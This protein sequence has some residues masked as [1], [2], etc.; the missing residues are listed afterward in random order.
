MRHD[1]NELLAAQPTQHSL[2]WYRVRLGK[3]TGSEVGRLMK[4]GK[5]KDDVFSK[6]AICYITEKVSERMLNPSVVM[7]DDLFEEYLLQVTAS[8]KALAWG[9]D[10]EMNARTMYSKLTG[11]KVTSCGAIQFCEF[12]ADSPDG[13]VLDESGT[14]EIKCP[15]NKVHTEYLAQVHDAESL[16]ALKPEYY[17]QCM[18][19]MVAASAEWCDWMSY[20]PFSSKPLHIVRLAHDGDAIG[21]MLTRVAMAEE[22][23]KNMIDK[24]KSAVCCHS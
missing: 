7:I 21:Q 15:S 5:G 9:N 20:C 8:S 19:H 13:L 10:Q 1:I 12:F 6:D 16:K 18:A 11:R 22:L 23:A 2:D 14:I 3:F 4:S 17:W 24:I